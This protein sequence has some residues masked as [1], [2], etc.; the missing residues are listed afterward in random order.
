VTPEADTTA[1]YRDTRLRIRDVAAAAGDGAT[2]VPACPAWTVRDVV[3]HL[4]GVCDDIL[5]GNLE[6]AGTDPWTLA[7]VAPR[8]DRSLADVLEEWDDLGRR[9]EALL[10]PGG[11]PAQLVFDEVTHE[12]D[13]R[14]ALGCPGAREDVAVDVALGF[15]VPAMSAS[16][17]QA[18]LPA[19]RARCGADEW[20]LGSGEPEVTLTAAAFDLLRSLSGRR[21]AEQIKGLDWSADPTPWL[22]AFTFGPF[23]LPI[24]PVD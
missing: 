1:V 14:A 4:A 20:I 8:A 7:H 15:A 6:G 22:P 18:D 17:G 19:I 16:V 21:T 13:L 23:T 24:T 11:A 2:A 12:H 3:A 9:V 10:G 5:A